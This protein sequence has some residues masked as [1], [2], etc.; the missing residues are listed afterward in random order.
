MR[1]YAF[2]VSISAALLLAG[3]SSASDD[4][5]P[6]TPDT[7]TTT[8]ERET[9]TRTTTLA[10]TTTTQAAAAEYWLR[11]NNDGYITMIVAE[12]YTDDQLEAAFLEV[13]DRYRNTDDGGWHVQID[14][15]DSQRSEGGPRQANGK[16]ALDNLG[17]AQTG[18]DVGDYEFRPL[19][20]RTPC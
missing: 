16:F 17:A 11:E 20:S 2:A 19:P 10:P 14:C 5:P 15:G 6:T 9:S 1:R 8:V 7:T 12:N 13:R 3:C 18:L 4:P